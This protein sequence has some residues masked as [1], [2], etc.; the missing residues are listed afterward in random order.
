[1]LFPVSVP[2]SS[3]S[4]PFLL[5]T[6]GVCSVGTRPPLSALLVVL[7]PQLRRCCTSRRILLS[8]FFF[9]KAHKKKK[10]QGHAVNVCSE[11]RLEEANFSTRSFSSS[12]ARVICKYGTETSQCVSSSCCIIREYWLRSLIIF[13]TWAQRENCVKCWRGWPSVFICKTFRLMVCDLKVS[14]MED[15]QAVFCPWWARLLWKNKIK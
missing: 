9:C 12:S 11:L 8:F 15:G 10:K 13:F 3:F 6:P 7:F 5:I 2:L 14:C 4:S 1:M